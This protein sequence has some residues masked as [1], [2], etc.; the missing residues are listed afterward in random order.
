MY[1]LCQETGI[2]AANDEYG[3]KWC[4]RHRKHECVAAF[5]KQEHVLTIQGSQRMAVHYLLKAEEELARALQNVM[6][7][8]SL[9]DD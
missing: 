9:Y 3:E 1:W 6:N 7:G 5:V 2:L 4:I 8:V